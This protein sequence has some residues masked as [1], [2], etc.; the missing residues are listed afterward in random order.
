[1]QLTCHTSHDADIH[2]ERVI[3]FQEYIDLEASLMSPLEPQTP[4]SSEPPS[5]PR[6]SVGTDHEPENDER[7]NDSVFGD[8]SHDI[9]EF[10]PVNT[11]QSESGLDTR[12][13]SLQNGQQT[14][15][16]SSPDMAENKKPTRVVTYRSPIQSDV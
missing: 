15:H 2:F 5:T 13:S 9:W 6:N 11:R 7:D 14:R 16:K 12:K 4:T 1:M 8:N 3:L 10:R